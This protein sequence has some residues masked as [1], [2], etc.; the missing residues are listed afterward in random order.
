M[1]YGKEVGTA[2]KAV[3]LGR[4]APWPSDTGAF[5]YSAMIA[6]LV[7]RYAKKTLVVTADH[8]RAS[9]HAP[10][11]IELLTSP[12]RRVSALRYAISGLPFASEPFC[13]PELRQAAKAAVKNADLIVLDHIGSVWAL[14]IALAEQKKGAQLV[15]CGP[16]CSFPILFGL[17]LN[18]A[19]IKGP[20]GGAVT[21]KMKIFFIPCNTFASQ[22]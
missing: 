9:H 15:G 13:T 17:P 6:R 10:Q 14:D 19:Y 16:P 3:I 20:F 11:G 21:Y 4:Y 18:Q 12:P 22:G 1:S 8:L 2:G 7:S 5:L